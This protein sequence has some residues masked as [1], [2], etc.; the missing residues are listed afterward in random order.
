VSFC[1]QDER[2]SAVLGLDPWVEPIPDRILALSATTPALY[3]R[4]DGWRGN[5]NDAFLRGIAERST[6][7][8]YWMGVDGAHHNDFVVTPLLSPFAARFG[9]KGPI[10][11]GRVIPIIDRYLV[12]FFDV[13][14]LGTGPAALDTASFDEVSVELIRPD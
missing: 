10:P 3:M 13:Y 12:G 14:L 6:E 9:L 5:E 7:T 8:T 2:C 4:S 11:A 1:L